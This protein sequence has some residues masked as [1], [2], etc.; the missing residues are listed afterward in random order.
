MKTEMDGEFAVSVG[1][2]CGG[3]DCL[4]DRSLFDFR[5]WIRRKVVVIKLRWGL[6]SKLQLEFDFLVVRCL[7]QLLR[8]DHELCR[9]LYSRWSWFWKCNRFG[10]DEAWEGVEQ[11]W[12]KV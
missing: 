4:L 12:R 9:F 10:D 1:V 7:V 11:R 2:R 8:V 6:W 5:F 3:F